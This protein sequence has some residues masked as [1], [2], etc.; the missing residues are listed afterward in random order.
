MSESFDGTPGS[1][2][3]PQS[4]PETGGVPP[5]VGTGT[6]HPASGDVPDPSGEVDGDRGR[7]VSGGM[8]GEG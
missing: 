8:I 6:T 5:K 2:G 7:D 3:G 4:R 1:Q